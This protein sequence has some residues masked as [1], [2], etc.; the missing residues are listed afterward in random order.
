MCCAD[1]CTNDDFVSAKPNQSVCVDP[2]GELFGDDRRI[3]GGA[4]ED[5]LGTTVCEGGMADVEGKLRQVLMEQGQTEAISTSQR[6]DIFER[7]RNGYEGLELVDRAE[8]RVPLLSGEGC[9]SLHGR[10][11]PSEQQPAEERSC[12][13]AEKPGAEV[14]EQ[15]LPVPEDG[16]E[17]DRRALPHDGTDGT[18]HQDRTGLVEERCCVVCS[19]RLAPRLER[20]PELRQERSVTLPTSD[21]RKAVSEKIAGRS[22]RV[23]SESVRRVRTAARAMSSVRG[24]HAAPNRRANTPTT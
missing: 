22:A 18:T 14:D 2:W 23:V 20:L 7:C 24:P 13:L 21:L 4:R 9:S 1:G 8:E 10:P 19:L 15:D 6:K 3:G 12:V 17:R 16:V 11:E 5:D